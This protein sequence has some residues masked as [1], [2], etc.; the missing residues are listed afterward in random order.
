VPS[1]LLNS[2]SG[3]FCCMGNQ[4]F[5]D[6]GRKLIYQNN[7]NPSDD[8]IDALEFL[9]E[10]SN[11][12]LEWREGPT[13]EHRLG[14]INFSVAGRGSSLQ[15]RQLYA[16]FD[17]KTAE[18][19]AMR[20]TL[21]NE[22]PELDVSIGGKISLDIYPRGNDKSQSVDWIMRNENPCY[23]VFVGDRVHASGNDQAAAIRI[24]EKRCGVWFNVHSWRETMALLKIGDLVNLKDGT[25]KK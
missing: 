25:T 2:A 4:L 24:D 17:K 7:F 1:S 11:Y 14:M 22:F 5:S 3:L 16:E 20:E 9:Y 19:E 23:I 8:L 13:I 6:G 15:Y 10:K 21:I 12:P 18:R